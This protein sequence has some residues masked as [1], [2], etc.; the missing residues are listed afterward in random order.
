[1]LPDELFVIAE[2]QSDNEHRGREENEVDSHNQ[3]PFL[4]DLLCPIPNP[5]REAGEQKQR[6]DQDAPECIDNPQ[7]VPAV[8]IVHC[9]FSWGWEQ[10][11]G[12]G[13]PQWRWC[14]EKQSRSGLWK[15]D[16]MQRQSK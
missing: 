7:D 1:M 3:E 15:V 14:Q 2:G 4:P 10:G 13:S 12:R 16:K 6:R 9:L 11:R 5:C 8:V